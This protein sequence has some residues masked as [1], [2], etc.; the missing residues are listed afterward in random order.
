M[1]E[2]QK[3]S[4]AHAGDARVHEGDPFGE[5]DEDSAPGES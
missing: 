4:V 1:K 2:W 5:D 3:H